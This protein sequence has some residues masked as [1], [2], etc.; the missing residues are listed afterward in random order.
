MNYIHSILYSSIPVEVQGRVDRIDICTFLWLYRLF[1]SSSDR[2]HPIHHWSNLQG[3]SKSVG[4]AVSSVSGFSN[5][6]IAHRNFIVF[7][8]NLAFITDTLDIVL[9]EVDR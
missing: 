5:S 3:T 4:S 1:G 8:S 9:N 7:T 6:E 2:R